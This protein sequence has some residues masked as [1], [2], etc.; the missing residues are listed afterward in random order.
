MGTGVSLSIKSPKNCKDQLEDLRK[1]NSLL[2]RAMK[3]YVSKFYGQAKGQL[4][5]VN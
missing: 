4:V 5:L 1:S 3:A 2:A